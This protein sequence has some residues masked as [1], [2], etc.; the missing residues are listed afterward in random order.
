MCRKSSDG[1]FV[2][3]SPQSLLLPGS[4]VRCDT[5]SQIAWKLI[6]GSTHAAIRTHRISDGLIRIN[7]FGITF[8]Y[9]YSFFLTVNNLHARETR[10]NI[11]LELETLRRTCSEGSG[12]ILG[13][14]NR[15]DTCTQSQIYAFAWKLIP[16]STLTCNTNTSHRLWTDPNQFLWGY[17]HIRL[18]ILH[19]RTQPTCSERKAKLYLPVKHYGKLVARVQ[20]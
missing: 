11:V 6:P 18:L 5:R 19:N 3:P 12:V 4:R 13:Q 8:L 14:W 7:C 20:G 2:Q 10:Q 15:C 1:N 9:G 17:A 16:V